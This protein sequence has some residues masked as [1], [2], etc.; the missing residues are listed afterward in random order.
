MKKQFLTYLKSIGYVIFIHAAAVLAAL[1]LPDLPNSS[2]RLTAILCFGLALTIL[3]PSYFFAKKKAERPVVYL[4][5]TVISHIIISPV[6]MAAVKILSAKPSWHTFYF[7]IT[8]AMAGIYFIAIALIDVALMISK[9]APASPEKA[10]KKPLIVSFCAG[11][12]ASLLCVSVFF[13]Y[14]RVSIFKQQLHSSMPATVEY[15]KNGKQEAYYNGNLSADIAAFLP[16][17]EGLYYGEI[18]GDE[19][20][21]ITV[22]GTAKFYVYPH[23]EG[24]IIKHDPYIGSSETYETTLTGFEYYMQEL[25]DL[26]GDEGFN[27]EVQQ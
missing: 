6:I 22:P 2:S 15:I 11:A 24:V 23:G 16:Y 3:S 8:E 14:A 18:S 13:S 12:L 7:T 25:Y 20:I 17:V 1:T 4:I 27:L 21:K 5:V 9:K 26:T 10:S 19:Y